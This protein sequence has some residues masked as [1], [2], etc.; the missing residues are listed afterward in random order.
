MNAFSRLLF[1]QKLHSTPNFPKN[2]HFLHIDTD[3]YLCVSG[4]KKS[5]FFGK[6]GVFSFL[7][8]PVFRFTLFALLPT[9][10]E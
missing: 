10:C 5:S 3:R 9:S 4:G 8:T 2:E 6:F 1:S 7:E